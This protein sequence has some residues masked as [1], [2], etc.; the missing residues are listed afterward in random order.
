MKVGVISDTHLYD[1]SDELHRVIETIFHDVGTIL[2][3]GDIVSLKVLQSF[4]DK[5]V[6]AVRGNM[7]LPDSKGVLKEKEVIEI[8]RFRIGLIH[9]WGAPVGLENKIR[10]R[11]GKVDAIVYGHT[12]RPANHTK[13]GVFFFNPGSF[14]SGRMGSPGS[15]GILHLDKEITGEIVTV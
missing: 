7:D 15:V 13:D 14:S 2:H 12:H 3:A 9:G 5:E 11:F 4:R 8:A 6:I 10:G 1:P